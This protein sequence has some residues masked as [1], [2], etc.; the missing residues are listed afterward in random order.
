MRLDDLEILEGAAKW[1]ITAILTS[2][3]AAV[4]ELVDILD[5]ERPCAIYI[6]PTHEQTAKAL[7]IISILPKIPIPLLVA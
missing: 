3:V 5:V 2:V 6:A 4:S 7:G 1:C